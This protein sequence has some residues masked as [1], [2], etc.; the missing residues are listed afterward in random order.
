[1]V[2]FGNRKRSQIAAEQGTFT[3]RWVMSAPKSSLTDREDFGSSGCL[4]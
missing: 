4:G 2:H 1:M 3:V